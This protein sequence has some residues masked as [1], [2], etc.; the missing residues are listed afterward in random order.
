MESKPFLARLEFSDLDHKIKN[1]INS[2][3]EYKIKSKDNELVENLR[4]ILDEEIESEKKNFYVKNESKKVET[5]KSTVKNCIDN[6]KKKIESFVEEQI[7]VE[8]TDF[9][10]ILNEAKS[11]A[12]ENFNEIFRSENK[13]TYAIYLLEV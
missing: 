5:A 4:K 2:L 1:E 12:I 11:L 6:H 9:D 8:T 10:K 13:D 3:F 7:F